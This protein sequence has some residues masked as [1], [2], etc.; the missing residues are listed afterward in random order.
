MFLSI[1]ANDICVLVVEYVRAG[2]RD[3]LWYATPPINIAPIPKPMHSTEYLYW[4]QQQ[5]QKQQ[6]S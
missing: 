6:G 4:K 2:K 3:V 5:R 1:I